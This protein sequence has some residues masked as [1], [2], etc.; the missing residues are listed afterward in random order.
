MLKAIQP[1]YGILIYSSLST[2]NNL[3]AWF[4][5]FMIDP[6][7]C[8]L[9]NKDRYLLQEKKKTHINS[10]LQSSESQC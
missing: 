9:I 7:F 2:I 6:L 10:N 4:I 1:L 5:F 3:K 8:F